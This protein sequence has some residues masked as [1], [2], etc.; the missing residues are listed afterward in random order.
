MMEIDN[1]LSAHLFLQ[2]DQMVTFFYFLAIYNIDYVPNSIKIQKL[3]ENLDI[4]KISSHKIDPNSLKF[5]PLGEILPNLVT[6]VIV[7]QMC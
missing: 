7:D 2:C 4:N 1:P 3:D 5:S 6:L